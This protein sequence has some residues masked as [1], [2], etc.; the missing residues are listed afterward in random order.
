MTRPPD[1]SARA[2]TAPLT[3]K[4]WTGL[5]VVP[6]LAMGLLTWALWSPD[7]DHGTATAAV[8]NLDEPV[9]VNDKTVPL[10]RELAGDLT[11]SDDPAY[12]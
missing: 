10:G 4:T 12:K 3:W 5:F 11:H 9:K 1:E 6:V 8:V 2:A 7:A